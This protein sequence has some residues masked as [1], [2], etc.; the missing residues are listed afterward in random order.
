MGPFLY[1]GYFPTMRL[2]RDANAVAI[3]AHPLE[4]I[5]ILDLLGSSKYTHSGNRVRT[6]VLVLPNWQ[7]IF[8]FYLVQ[9]VCCGEGCSLSTC[10]V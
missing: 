1:Q 9:A 10:L 2:L 6:K 3:C 5:I 8:V 7:N 4:R